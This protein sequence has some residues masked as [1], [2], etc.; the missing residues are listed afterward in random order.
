MVLAAFRVLNAPE[1]KLP[2]EAVT[3]LCEGPPRALFVFD[4]KTAGELL[5]SPLLVP[6]S[7]QRYY[8]AVSGLDRNDFPV[9]SEAFERTPLSLSGS[10]HRD[11]RARVTPI[12]RRVEAEIDG[13]IDD[14]CTEYLDDVRSRTSPDIVRAASDFSDRVGRAMAAADLGIRWQDL[15]PIPNEI[16]V[17]FPS[18]GRI[19]D[20][21]AKFTT[22]RDRVLSRLLEQGRDEEDFWPI[23]ILMMMNRDSLQG[24]VMH[25]YMHLQNGTAAGSANECASAADNVSL[26]QCRH[27]MEDSEIAGRKWYAGELVYIAPHLL[28]RRDPPPQGTDF[29]F[30]P[31]PHVCPGRKL[32]LRI[33]DALIAALRRE[34]LPEGF[35][36]RISKF[37]RQ[38]VL[39][40]NK[41]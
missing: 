40:A 25:M 19:R 39:M 29:T 17:M 27:V 18:A 4:P 6:T 22:I 13:W 36:P 12:Y 3:V 20:I 11:A 35:F 16:F 37:H 14:F 5:R 2:Q 32:S 31:G 34:P 7:A 24:T 38:L 30:G 1:D 9:L 10:A 21:E 15:P 41:K 23:L 8:E 33:L 28:H 26:L